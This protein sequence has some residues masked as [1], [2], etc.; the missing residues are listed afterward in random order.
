MTS[1][2][3]GDVRIEKNPW[4]ILFLLLIT[5]LGLL[6]NGY[7]YG[8]SDQALYLPMILRS[9]T[10]SLFPNDYLFDESSEGYNLWAPTMTMLARLFPLEWTF[11]VGYLLTR[12][13]FFW[14]VYHVSLNLFGSRGAA[15]L[16]VL[17][18][19]L[20]KPVGQTAT[21]TQITFFTLRSTAKPLAIAFLIPYFHRRLF[22]AAIICGITFIIHPI[23]AIPIVFLLFFRLLVDCF[24]DDWRTPAK[25]FVIFLL[26]ILP[27][28]V[29]VFL[30]DRANTSDLS[31]FSRS[32]PQWMEIIRQRNSYIFLS[33]WNK[34]AFR[35]LA[36]YYVLLV[37]ILLLRREYNRGHRE[38]GFW[39]YSILIVCASLFI[40]GIVFV[41]WYPLSLV[42]QLQVVRS[43]FLVIVM[44][45]IYVAWLLWEGVQRW[46]SAFATAH[47]VIR[48]LL[49]L[50]IGIFIPVYIATL[51]IVRSTNQLILGGISVIC[52]WAC[53]H[54]KRLHFLWRVAMGLLWCVIILL[55]RG[56]FT[57]ALDWQAFRIVLMGFVFIELTHFLADWRDWERIKRLAAG[58][59][60]ITT[61]L[62]VI[63]PNFDILKRVVMDG[64]FTQH[65]NLPGRL[66]YSDWI[67]V[68]R[69]CQ[70]N[71]PTD[72]M[73]LV[74]PNRGGFRI[75]AHRAI[76]GDRKD[77]APGVFS[78]SYAK[79]WR[80]RMD[81]L[82]SY[83]SFDKS[84]FNQLG[85]K[86][87]ASFAVTRKS[88]KL[89][90]P[91]A[92]QNNEFAVYELDE[93]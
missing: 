27:L 60:I 41:E 87:G 81:E 37:A 73:F 71:T 17:L 19:I 50:P 30:I 7:G 90:F 62:V 2:N 43:S 3:D 91:I 61:A 22:S 54:I 42:V 44:A 72:A 32:D 76:V 31:L 70:A 5:I 68:Q 34:D 8:V 51:F 56:F 48:R 18:L 29:R 16:A 58:C 40:I 69:W 55:F 6:V 53:F 45:M 64:Q 4:V 89:N 47:E 74:L 36:A 1:R 57:G 24:R 86:Y 63:T 52:W 21:A 11:F 84:R 25:A 77:G 82:D 33:A 75:H 15:A 67:D 49:Y 23:T 12:F 79:K 66:P 14:A 38:T 26:C 93:R 20:P 13:L 88:H 39:T 9:V 65:V 85:E 46:R 35:S 78:E 10:P 28:L 59:L 83:D 92:Y 80:A